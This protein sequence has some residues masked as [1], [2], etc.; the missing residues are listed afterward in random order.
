[1]NTLPLN[2]LLD[3][4]E[5]DIQLPSGYRKKIINTHGD[6][7]LSE[8]FSSEQIKRRTAFYKEI[9]AK[10]DKIPVIPGLIN[11]KYSLYGWDETTTIRVYMRE[12]V[13]KIVSEL[14]S[15]NYS[16]SVTNV[17]YKNEK[18]RNR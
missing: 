11:K 15:S 8:T 17:N 13:T 4:N 9:N 18:W 14:F 1:M 12:T 16:L 2:E 7:S 5:Q 3:Q 10:R 6:C